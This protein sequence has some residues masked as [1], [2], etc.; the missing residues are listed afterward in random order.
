MMN[1]LEKIKKLLTQKQMFD[2]T[3]KVN[4]FNK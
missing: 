1:F 3:G 4:Y 2:T